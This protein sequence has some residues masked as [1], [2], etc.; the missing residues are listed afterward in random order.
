MFQAR[1]HAFMPPSRENASLPRA[2]S[3][4]AAMRLVLPAAHTVTTGPSLGTSTSASAAGFLAFRASYAST[5]ILPGMA[6]SA[7]S[8]VGRTSRIVTG[9]PSSSH[10]RKVSTS[11]GSMR[12]SLSTLRQEVQAYASQQRP[13]RA[14]GRG[15]HGRARVLRLHRQRRNRDRDNRRRSLCLEA[16]LLDAPPVPR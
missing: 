4:S 13:L 6:H 3:C 16:P 7:H 9:R 15:T 8:A 11:I 5:W 2:A 14:D 10:V 1:L 12:V